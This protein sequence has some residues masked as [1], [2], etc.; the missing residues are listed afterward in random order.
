MPRRKGVA[1]RL[2]HPPRA[3][4]VL[5]QTLH[6]ESFYAY[7][8]VSQRH[9]RRSSASA[10]GNGA[11]AEGGNNTHSRPRAIRA[12]SGIRGALAR[13]L[14]RAN[15]V[16]GRRRVVRI[17]KSYPPDAHMSRSRLCYFPRR[18]VLSAGTSC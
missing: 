4:R 16:S 11:R 12:V 1:R 8:E 2:Q 15:R 9:E 14:A 10:S 7:V 3:H 18:R 17:A 13:C 6:T 5:P